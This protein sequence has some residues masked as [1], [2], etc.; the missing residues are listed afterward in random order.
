MKAA[1]RNLS[2]AP[3]TSYNIG[4]VAAEAHFPEN[5]TELYDTVR[6]LDQRGIPWFMLGGGSNVLIGDGFWEGAVVITT[7]MDEWSASDDR[8]T[9]GAGLPSTRVAGIALDHE[10]AGLEFLYRLPGFIGGA[11]AGNARY[12]NVSISDVLVAVRACHP[13][14]GIRRFRTGEL[15]TSYKRIDIFEKGWIAG[16]IELSWRSGNREAISKRMD[17]IERF[18]NE[19]GHFDLPS[20]GCIF[21]NDHENNI[22]AG[23]LIDSLGLKGMR[24]GGAAVWDRHANFIVNTGN[25]TARD[26]VE[27]MNSIEA[28]V[29]EKTGVRLEREVRLFGNFDRGSADE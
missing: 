1:E 15:E 23:R 27:L 7:R 4:G 13:D 28:A 24:V 14:E 17:A 22:Q 6:K 16:E 19:S 9:C 2:L 20:C 10:R 8:L 18:R 25:A 3:Y 12:D 5:T 26:V 21:K 29:L 11:L